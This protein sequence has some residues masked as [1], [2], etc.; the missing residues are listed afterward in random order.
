MC[1]AFS[2]LSIVPKIWRIWIW[3]NEILTIL[4]LF[5]KIEIWTKL[6]ISQVIL[7]APKRWTTIVVYVSRTIPVKIGRQLNV[8]NK[9][10]KTTFKLPCYRHVSWD[11][12]Y[13]KE[14]LTFTYGF[15][16]CRNDHLWPIVLK[17]FTCMGNATVKINVYGL[18]YCRYLHDTA[19]CT[20]DIYMIRPIVL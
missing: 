10:S 6:S 11:T 9:S 14:N 13:Y 3:R 4:V 5:N 1:S 12:L 20:V 15:N 19:Y 2:V 8:I 16:F 7:T 17:M 18:L